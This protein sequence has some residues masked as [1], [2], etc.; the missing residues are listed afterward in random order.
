MILF[1]NWPNSLKYGKKGSTFIVKLPISSRA[2][3]I[4]QSYSNGIHY[5]R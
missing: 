5:D 4:I 2:V 1:G 3:Q